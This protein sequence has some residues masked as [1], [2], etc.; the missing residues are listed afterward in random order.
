[1]K[2]NISHDIKSLKDETI[3]EIHTI[4]A[5]FGRTYTE[6]IGFVCESGKRVMVF[7]GNTYNPLP[8]LEEMRKTT[9]FTVD[10]IAEKIRQD[11]LLK[12]KRE[13]DAIDKKKHDYERLKAELGLKD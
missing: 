7:A 1:M 13:Q 2:M 5:E 10:E 4:K 9:F 12:R 11:E 8:T 6:Y 3:K